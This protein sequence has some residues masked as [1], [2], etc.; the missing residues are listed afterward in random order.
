MNI[1]KKIIVFFKKIPFNLKCI[2][3]VLK[4][5]HSGDSAKSEAK[6]GNSGDIAKSEGNKPNSGD[7]AKSEG[8]KPN[9]RDGVKSNLSWNLRKKKNT[10]KNQ[11]TALLKITPTSMK[12]IWCNH[13]YSCK[14]LI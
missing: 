8:N 6:K 5:R 3:Q 14:G 12:M 11:V 2:I 1:F 13:Q 4:K 10:T 7:G 9:S